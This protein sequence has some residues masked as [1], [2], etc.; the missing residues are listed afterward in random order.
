MTQN[1]SQ[2]FPEFHNMY[3]IVIY[4]Q[5]VHYMLGFIV[6][7]S[8]VK[9][10]KLLEFN[11][12]M[13]YLAYTLCVAARDLPGYMFFYGTITMAFGFLGLLA[14]G[15]LMSLFSTYVTVLETMMLMSLGGVKSSKE[16]YFLNN[17]E[18]V[19]SFKF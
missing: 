15:Y 3:R 18:F 11:T 5:L 6:F 12:R 16:Q 4:D 9:F 1:I 2:N 10:Y 13:H 19:R 8:T 17:L 7:V 14:F